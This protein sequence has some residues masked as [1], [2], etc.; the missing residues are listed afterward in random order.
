[1]QQ[2]RTGGMSAAVSVGVAAGIG[3]VCFLLGFV[4]RHFCTATSDDP[5]KV[6][7]SA[8]CLCYFG[9]MIIIPCVVQPSEHATMPYGVI[10]DV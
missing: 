10:C 7:G 2:Q 8:P 1:M 6:C 5:Q 9:R 4:L 3:A